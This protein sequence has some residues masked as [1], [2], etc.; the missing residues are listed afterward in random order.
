MAT[1]R[2]SIPAEYNKCAFDVGIFCSTVA[3]C[4]SNKSQVELEMETEI[5][6]KKKTKN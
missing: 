1:T 6:L 2:P 4:D 5:F 3:Q